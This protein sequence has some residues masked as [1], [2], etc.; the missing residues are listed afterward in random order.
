MPW[1]CYVLVHKSTVPVSALMKVYLPKFFN[2]DG[3]PD[4]SKV[5]N[6]WILGSGYREVMA[7]SRDFLA[8][9][10]TISKALKC[11]ATVVPTATIEDHLAQIEGELE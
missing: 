7:S 5:P 4:Y 6:E 8:L 2:V 10:D 9:K 1:C 11:V 3:K